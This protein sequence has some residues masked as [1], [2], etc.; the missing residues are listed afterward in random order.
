M[1][2]CNFLIVSKTYVSVC[3]FAGA[4]WRSGEIAKFQFLTPA[5]W[6]VA[7][8]SL[9]NVPESSDD[10]GIFPFLF[11]CA[12]PGLW[13]KAKFRSPAIPWNEPLSTKKGRITMELYEK[14]NSSLYPKSLY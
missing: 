9:Q 14:T 1:F 2:V 4:K 3:V 13:I 10:G 11:C 6:G 7:T 12:K 5:N 8:F